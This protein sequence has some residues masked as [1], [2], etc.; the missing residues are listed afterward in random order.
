MQGLPLNIPKETEEFIRRNLYLLESQERIQISAMA[1]GE[2]PLAKE[3][4]ACVLARSVAA[5][6]FLRLDR[7]VPADQTQMKVR[8]HAIHI[9]LLNGVAA[10]ENLI[11]RCLYPQAATLLRQQVEGL[12]NLYA[13][14]TAIFK[15]RRP[16]RTAIL[17]RMKL[18][19]AYVHLTEL[20]HLTHPDFLYEIQGVN[21]ERMTSPFN[22]SLSK[23]LLGLHAISLHWLGAEIAW[24]RPF[25]SDRYQSEEEEGYSA[26]VMGI[27][28]DVGFVSGSPTTA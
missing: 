19:K 3:H 20:S 18:M 4:F 24:L 26:I 7:E 13:L 1:Q 8:C 28:I 14:R 10:I 15:V 12:C 23:F 9:A 16:P 2:L 25:A 27:L 11:D 17:K 5:S 6:I 22:E 21:G